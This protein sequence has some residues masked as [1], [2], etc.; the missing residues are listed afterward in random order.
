MIAFVLL[1]ARDGKTI[2]P[3]AV[4]RISAAAV[5]ELPFAPASSL[6]W[7]NRAGS[8]V[9]LAWQAFT[10]HAQIG[11]HWY[12]DPDGGLTL[13]TGHCW[14]RDGGWQ[15]GIA[16]PWAEQLHRWLA[17]HS[18]ET[19]HEALFGLYAIVRL[20]PDGFGM[21]AADLLGGGPLFTSESPERFALANRAG[22]AAAASTGFAAE[23]ER[24]PLAMSWLVFWDSP[25][26]DDSGYWD[27]TRLPFDHQIVFDAD[28]HPRIEPRPRRFWHRPGPSPT[29]GVYEEMLDEVDADI[30]AALRTIAKL[31]VD[32][33]ELRLSGGKDSRMLAALLHDEGLTDRLRLHTYGIP[34][35]ADV[36]CAE[37][38]AQALDLP[39]TF[40]AREGIPPAIEHQRLC[41]H[42]WLVEGGAN[43]WDN[44][45]VPHRS[46]G[47][48]MTGVGGECTSFGPTSTAGLRAQTVA[49]VKR[50]YAVKDNFDPARLLLPEVRRHCHHVVDDWVDLQ[51]QL[52]EEPNRIASLF[53]TQQRTRC[54]AG[55]S[56]AVKASLWT[57]PF[58][59]P[60]YIRFR[61]LLP[62]DDRANPRVHLDLLR[63]CRVDLA[64]IP[65]AGA[66]WP[67]GA[68][69]RFPDADRLR[70][71]EPARTPPGMPSGWRTAAVASLRPMLLDELGDRTNPI[72]EIVDYEATR[73][74]L[75]RP[76][77]DA[78]RLRS[79]YGAVTGSIWLS[80]REARDQIGQ[81]W[82]GVP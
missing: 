33:L 75:E 76:T 37:L 2:A 43:G 12:V 81:A 55:P 29:S 4:D 68:V 53:I 26:G 42:V 44:A 82:E 79:L 27:A 49:D 11:S 80:R 30:R 71:I 18:I 77:I 78:P 67:E 14:P 63:R 51:A 15:H 19:A 38:V 1:G 32:E 54:W 25:I 7:T 66:R 22:L 40:E 13:F 3:A 73:R 70:A 62:V 65:L 23:P 24:D 46:S 48:T 64:T 74:L 69:S 60:S 20:D 34:G 16:T 10:E 50:L 21:A 39:W 17:L 58:L 72:F 28:R 8:I 5:P 9:V 57:A 45:G 6:R 35:Q 36:Q 61:Q 47:L 52:G 59:V 41:R 56:F 31:P